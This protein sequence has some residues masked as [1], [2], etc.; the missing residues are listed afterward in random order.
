MLLY[1]RTNED[2]QPD[3]EYTMSGNQIFLK[4]LDLNQDFKNIANE[5]NGIVQRF[6]S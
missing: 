1:A 6:F 5:L 4:T 3:S 2:V